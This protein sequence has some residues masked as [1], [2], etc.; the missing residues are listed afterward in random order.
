MWRGEG[1]P[2]NIIFQNCPND[3]DEDKEGARFARFVGQRGDGS[4]YSES[5]SSAS[6]SISSTVLALLLA[7][8]DSGFPRVLF[9]CHKQFFT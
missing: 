1:I 4:S 5:K 6:S 3:A 7:P 9:Y 2:V 8:F